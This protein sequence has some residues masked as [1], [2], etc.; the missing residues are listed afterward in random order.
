MKRIFRQFWP[1]ITLIAVVT[2][3]LLPYLDIKDHIVERNASLGAGAYGN[4]TTASN[5]NTTSLNFTSPNVSGTDTVGIVA[6]SSMDN[7]TPSGVSWNGSAMTSIVSNADSNPQIRVYYITAPTAGETTVNISF[8]SGSAVVATATFFTG[9]DQVDPIGAASVAAA[10]SRSI[11][12]EAA[13]SVFYA[14]FNSFS[15]CNDSNFTV[16][17]SLAERSHGSITGGL[18]DMSLTTGDKVTTATG[19]YTGSWSQNCGLN[20]KIAVVEIKEAVAAG[21][22]ETSAPVFMADT[23]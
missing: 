4:S 16:G 11:D 3:L 22:G 18:T 17:S 23:F 8:A 9:I 5:G 10:T 12:T 21:G 19:S 15:Q 14:A 13:N 20:H 1:S 7:R 6:V 2:V